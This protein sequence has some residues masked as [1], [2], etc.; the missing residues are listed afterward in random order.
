[1]EKTTP[2]PDKNVMSLNRKSPSTQPP[3]IW[4]RCK[5]KRFFISG[6]LRFA[7]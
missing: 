7:M 4:M 5:A 1:V 6:D 2:Q 3:T